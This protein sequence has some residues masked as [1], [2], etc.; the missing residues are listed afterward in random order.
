MNQTVFH[1][2]IRGIPAVVWACVLGI[3]AMLSEVMA[4]KQ[5][6]LFGVSAGAAFY[7]PRIRLHQNAPLPGIEFK[8]AVQ[9]G[10]GGNG[11]FIFEF[12]S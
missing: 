3:G 1:R 5:P 2:A 6:V 8:G 4:Q 11:N 7:Q 10:D 9:T 12:G